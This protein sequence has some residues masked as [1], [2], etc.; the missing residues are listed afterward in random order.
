VPASQLLYSL[1][2][3]ELHRGAETLYR[4]PNEDKARTV[5]DPWFR[6]N[7]KSKQLE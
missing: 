4:D 1:A 2:E 7:I 3:G 5:G 6:R